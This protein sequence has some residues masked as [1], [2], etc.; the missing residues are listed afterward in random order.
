G[1]GWGSGVSRAC[2][3]ALRLTSSRATSAGAAWYP[4]EVTVGEGFDTTFTFRLSS[5]SLRCNTMDGVYTHC[6]SRGADGLA[7]VI[8]GEG[9]TALGRSGMGMGYAGI[10]NMLAVEFDTHYNPE[11]L[12]QYENH[13]SV[14]T[15]GW[16][17]AGSAHGSHSLGSTPNVPDLTDQE[18]TARAVYTPI[19]T[20]EAVS[21]PNFQAS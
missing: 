3:P 17:D 5:P 7:F 9:P 19:V 18:V 4:R 21:H 10:S 11:M 15:R 14:Q 8:Q 2:G 20:P 16:R 12:E 6:R 13:V 1:G